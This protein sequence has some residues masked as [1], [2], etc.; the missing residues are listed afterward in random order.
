MAKAPD[1]GS[2]RNIHVGAPADFHQRLK[3]V[4]AKKGVKL[5]NYVLGA[6]TAAVER[7][8]KALR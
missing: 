3:V 1:S 4:C 6:L 7:D 2:V 5:K 8:E